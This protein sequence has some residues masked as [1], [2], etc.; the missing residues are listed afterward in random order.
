MYPS[1][2]TKYFSGNCSEKE[3]K[4][5]LNW[6]QTQKGQ[7]FLRKQIRRDCQRLTDN[8]NSFRCRDI[9]TI[10][11]F[12]RILN[13]I[14][15][16]EQSVIKDGTAGINKRLIFEDEPLWKISRK[17]ERIYDVSIEF[18]SEQLKELNLTADLKPKNA[19]VT[20]QTIATML[21]IKYKKASSSNFIWLKPP[22]ASL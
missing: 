10:S 14:K 13:S 8:K 17:L 7:A 20:V 1:L 11:V 22:G 9:D 21:D 2:I 6:F 16:D 15:A 18:Q 12:N 5:V 4:Q 19:E 3:R